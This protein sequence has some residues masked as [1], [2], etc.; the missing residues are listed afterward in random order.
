MLSVYGVYDLTWTVAIV[1]V[2][3]LHFLE[4]STRDIMGEALKGDGSN[5]SKYEDI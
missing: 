5:E 1:S 2:H 4:N 3:I